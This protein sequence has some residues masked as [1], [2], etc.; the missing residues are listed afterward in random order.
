MTGEEKPLCRKR[1]AKGVKKQERSPV[2]GGTETITRF[3]DG[4]SIRHCG[5]PNAMDMYYD[6]NGEEC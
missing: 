4:S 5:G 1:G 3:A 2:S 6:Q